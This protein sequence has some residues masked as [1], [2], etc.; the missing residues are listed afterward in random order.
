[1]SQLEELKKKIPTQVAV[2]GGGSWA[3]ALV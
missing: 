3:T 1:M 2:I